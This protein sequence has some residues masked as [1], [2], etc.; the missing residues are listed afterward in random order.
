MVF[1]CL[2]VYLFAL[3]MLSTISHKNALNPEVHQHSF[4]LIPSGLTSA[5]L[6][7]TQQVA[8]QASATGMF[9]AQRR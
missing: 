9:P 5:A 4:F 2:F 7:A 8:A 3:E 6:V 1:F